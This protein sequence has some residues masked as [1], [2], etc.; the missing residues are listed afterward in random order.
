MIKPIL[1]W[2]FE[3]KILCNENNNLPFILAYKSRHFGRFLE[4]FFLILLIRGPNFIKSKTKK[5]W[6][7]LHFE[8]FNR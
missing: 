2:T 8:V 7:F 5:N 6:L 3:V 4:L 1:Y